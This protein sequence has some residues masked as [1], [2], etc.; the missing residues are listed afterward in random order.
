MLPWMPVLLPRMLVL[1]F[2]IRAESD[3]GL[4]GGGRDV[5]GDPEAHGEDRAVHQARDLRRRYGPG[6]RSLPS[7]Y[8]RVPSRVRVRPLLPQGSCNAPCSTS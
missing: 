8:R 5:E 3:A 1:L 6:A 2:C 7:S 4:D